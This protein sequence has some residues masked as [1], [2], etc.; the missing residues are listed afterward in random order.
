MAF[1]GLAEAFISST[2]SQASLASGE[3]APYFLVAS[4]AAASALKIASSTVADCS[5]TLAVGTRP[6]LSSPS[7]FMINRFSAKSS[8]FLFANDA[9]AVALPS[10]VN[11][12]NLSMCMLN[13]LQTS[14]PSLTSHSTSRFFFMALAGRAAAFIS[15]TASQ[16]SLASGE[17]APNFLVASRAFASA[18]KMSSS[19][20]AENSLDWPIAEERTAIWNP[21]AQNTRANA[22]RVR[23]AFIF[24]VGGKRVWPRW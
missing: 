14:P 24:R 17:V 8:L 13:S 2:V 12:A 18:A 7:S 1:A 21:D 10:A 23:R 3:V 9:A 5:S 16:A 19:V 22:M 4:R 20:A 11:S 6:S 15:S